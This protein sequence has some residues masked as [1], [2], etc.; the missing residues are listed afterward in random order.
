MGGSMGVA[1]GFRR[2]GPGARIC[3][4]PFSKVR[5]GEEVCVFVNIAI[6]SGLVIAVRRVEC[7]KRWW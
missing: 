4:I 6:F 2:K 7:R 3:D 1:E 5:E